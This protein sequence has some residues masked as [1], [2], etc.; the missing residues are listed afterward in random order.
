MRF[1]KSIAEGIAA[2]LGG[3]LIAYSFDA[4]V[5]A[6]S[7]FAWGPL[8]LSAFLSEAPFARMES[9]QHL[10]NLKTIIR[11]MYVDDQM[12]RLICFN[13]TFF[14]LATFYVVWMLQPYWQYQGV[15]LTAFGLLWAAQSFVVAFATRVAVPCERRFGAVPVLVLMGVLPIV[16]Y[17][18]MAGF[19]GMFGI[20]LSFSFFFSR[21]LNQVILTD[22]LNSRVPSSFRATA[23]SI[24]SFM[25]RGVF[26]VTGPLIG[27]LIASFGMHI[28]LAILGAVVGLF[29]TLWLIPLLGEIRE[30]V[31]KVQDQSTIVQATRTD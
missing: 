19:G 2:L 17:I 24:T 31:V 7:L 10:G 12:L 13:I 14:G 22:A 5:F 11:H 29:F 26:I 20:L 3:F 9:N 23:N 1:V 4:V 30:R 15:A 16:G 25:F 28:T 21:G 27:L 6:N 8:I 18:G